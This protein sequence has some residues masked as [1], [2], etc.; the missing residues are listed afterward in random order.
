M[1]GRVGLYVLSVNEGDKRLSVDPDDPEGRERLAETVTDLL[2][3]GYQISVVIG[4]DKDG[5]EIRAK[6]TQFDRQT[7]EYVVEGTT[8]EQDEILG[9]R[10]NPRKSRTRRLP[11]DQT[12]ADAVP[13][14]AGGS[15]PELLWTPENS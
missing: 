4:R 10:M 15:A 1:Y 6:V 2:R 5:Q 11:M 12:P 7:L 14:T 13:P 8:G 3:K 9:R